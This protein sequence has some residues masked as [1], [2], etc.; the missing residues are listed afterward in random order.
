MIRYFPIYNQPSGGNQSLPQVLAIGDRPIKILNAVDEV[1]YY[2]LNAQDATNHIKINAA[3]SIDNRIIKLPNGIFNDYVEFIITNTDYLGYLLELD[4]N[5][6][7]NYN[8]KLYGE[9]GTENITFPKYSRVTIKKQ[10]TIDGADE[11]LASSQNI[12]GLS[13]VLAIGDRE[14]YNEGIPITSSSLYLSINHVNKLLS[15]T[16]ETLSGDLVVFISD[17]TKILNGEFKIFNGSDKKVEIKPNDG[18]ILIGD[19][20]FIPKG[21]TAIIKYL[22]LSSGNNINVNV[23]SV[24]YQ[25]NLVLPT[26]STTQV[27]EALLN[28]KLDAAPAVATLFKNEFSNVVSYSRYNPGVYKIGIV[29]YVSGQW[30]CEAIGQNSIQGHYSGPIDVTTDSSRGFILTTQGLSDINAENCMLVRLTK[31]I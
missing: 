27:Y 31:K 18:I 16:N 3:A 15:L 11:Y 17:D 12:S 28:Q 10:N 25:Y 23:F 30:M 13:D 19:N 22:R 1:I 24:N 4:D 5:V 20:L 6:L 26:Q 14:L 7:V 9:E 21:A 8:G 2:N 29:G